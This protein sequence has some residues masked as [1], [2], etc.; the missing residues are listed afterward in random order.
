MFLLKNLNSFTHK[1]IAAKTSTAVIIVLLASSLAATG[2]VKPVAHEPTI[3]T[4]RLPVLSEPATMSMFAKIA[5]MGFTGNHGDDDANG[6]GQNGGGEGGPPAAVPSSQLNKDFNQRPRDEPAVTVNPA[7]G[8]V[9]AGANDYGIGGPVGGGSYTHLKGASFPA[10]TYFP[11]FSLMCAGGTGTSCIYSAPPIGTGDPVVVYSQKDNEYYYTSIGFSAD[12][13]ASGVYLYRS[14]NGLDWTRPINKR[15]APTA[16]GGGVRTITYWDG[17]FTGQ[18]CSIFNDKEWLAIDNTP[19]SPF[20]GR[21]YVTWSQFMLDSTGSVYSASPIELAFSDDKGN[22]FSNPIDVTGS[23]VT[24][25]NCLGFALNAANAGRCVEDQFSVPVV[26][27]DG[28]VYVVFINGQHEIPE[29]RDQYLVTRVHPAATA[30]GF[31]VDGAYLATFPVYDGFDDYPVQ[32]TGGQGRSTLCNSN[33]RLSSTEGFAINISNGQLYIA[34]ADDR[35]HAG[36]FSGQHVGPRTTNPATSY[37]CPA[38]LNTDNDVF[39]ITS[40]NNG[41]SWTSPKLVN[42]DKPSVT[43]ANNKDQF[44]PWVAANANGQV[45]VLYLDRRYDTNPIPNKFSRATVGYTTDLV[46]WK[47]TLIAQF[48]SNYDNAFTA[49][50]FIGDYNHVVL[51]NDG[52]VYGVWTGV[53]PNKTFEGNP[54][55][56]SDIFIAIYNVNGH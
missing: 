47:E 55:L 5:N 35:A 1:I 11:P 52:T 18:D 8:T 12:N 45:V 49:G 22:T 36:E 34:W 46:N 48:P 39:I 19:T 13:C 50:A 15:F 31:T 29:H 40:T 51:T 30:S 10:E 4:P 20:Y 26:A 25:P 41:V 16:T 38:G 28:T 3:A 53:K 21:I 9:V 33:F 43:P 56:A 37:N 17:S 7:T 54:V 14:P 27:K 23:I 2:V 24:N 32:T 42:Q 6:G 44:Y